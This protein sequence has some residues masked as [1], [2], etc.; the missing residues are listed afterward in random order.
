M[1]RL[2]FLIFAIVFWFHTVICQPITNIC[3]CDSL[4]KSLFEPLLTGELLVSVENISGQQYYYDWGNADVTLFTGEVAYNKTLRYNG[5][6]NEMIWLTPGKNRSIKL[7]K[8]RV[9]EVYFK[10]NHSLFRNMTLERKSDILTGKKDSVMIFAEVLLDGN[11]AMYVYHRV[12][13]NAYLT[14]NINNQLTTVHLITNSPV[15][16]I[17]LPHSSSWIELH[18]INRWVLVHLFPEKKALVRKLIHDTKIKIKTQFDF[19]HALDLVN[20][21]L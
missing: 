9:K 21:N 3:R 1:K 2:F 6:L 15:Y 14:E 17:K 11:M 16:Y 18:H 13:H 8:T 20:K 7:D 12:I 4:D 19:A 5:F 10:N